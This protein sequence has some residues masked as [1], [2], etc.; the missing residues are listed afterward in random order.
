MQIKIRIDKQELLNEG[1]QH[2]RSIPPTKLT[3]DVKGAEARLSQLSLNAI[4]FTDS[5]LQIAISSK[6]TVKKSTLLADVQ[7]EGMIEL[8]C[9]TSYT[10]E[11]D[12]QLKTKFQYDSH[13]WIENPDVNIG[14]MKLSVTNI[15]DKAIE[16]RQDSIEKMVNQQMAAF[17]DLSKHIEK[18][19]PFL[20]HTVPLQKTSVHFAAQLSDLVIKEINDTE[21]E[22]IILAELIGEPEIKLGKTPF[23]SNPTPKL[24]VESKHA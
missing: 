9:S 24:N 16:L 13:R 19:L 7:G 20:T 18:V 2:I 1:N 4:S 14:I 21:N 23:Q 15:I 5:L 3:F 8:I 17:S 10:L 6:V 22:V 11:P 12:W